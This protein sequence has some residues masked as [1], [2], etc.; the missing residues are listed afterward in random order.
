[1]EPDKLAR[2]ILEIGRNKP[3][4]RRVLLKMK[5]ISI[6]HRSIPRRPSEHL[7]QN[8]HPPQATISANFGFAIR[9]APHPTFGL[10]LSPAATHPD[11]RRDFPIHVTASIR[12]HNLL[13]LA[14]SSFHR[15][16]SGDAAATNVCKSYRPPV[17]L[18]CKDRKPTVSS[19]YDTV[20]AI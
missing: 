7:D 11:P 15:T 13:V 5:M 17:F 9:G 14:N 1:M 12:T 4:F 20:G 6:S 8:S 18:Q 10:L 2:C 16:L 3:P 19:V